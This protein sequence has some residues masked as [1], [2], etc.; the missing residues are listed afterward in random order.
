MICNKI[1]KIIHLYEIVPT[2]P[3]LLIVYVIQ[4]YSSVSNE[5]S[6]GHSTLTTGN[7]LM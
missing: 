6:T 1:L 3:P 7:E 5:R 2:N 4:K